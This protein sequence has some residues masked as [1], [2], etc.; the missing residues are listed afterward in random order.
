MTESPAV[1]ASAPASAVA[2]MV[3]VAP[4]NARLGTV[5]V[6]VKVLAAPRRG[7]TV[8]SML[9]V[10]VV[11]TGPPVSPVPL[12]TLVTVPPLSVFIVGV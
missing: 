1:S 6:A 7:T 5:C 10:P 9:K 11:V 4:V 2:V 12:A 8:V 3:P